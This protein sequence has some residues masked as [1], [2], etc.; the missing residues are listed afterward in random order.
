MIVYKITNIINGKVY[1]GQ[2]KFT[3]EERFEHHCK[4]ALEE[5]A[6]FE[7]SRAIKKYGKEKFKVEVLEE[8]KTRE[9][10]CFFEIA[11]IKKYNSTNRDVGY[12]MTNGGEGG[13]TYLSKSDEEMKQIKLKISEA[14]KG[15]NNGNSRNIK[16][17][18]VLTGNVFHFGSVYECSRFLREKWNLKKDDYSSRLPLRKIKE[19]EM[20]GFTNLVFDRYLFADEE[21]DFATHFAKGPFIKGSCRW[22][23]Y[24]LNGNLVYVSNSSRELAEHFGWKYGKDFTS[25]LKRGKYIL[26]RLGIERKRKNE[27]K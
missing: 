8:V 20:Y 7:L 25:K 21:K 19:T 15:A 4:K 11:Y 24:D 26:E 5:N 3:A 13:N 27:N 23:V 22:K 14:N 9:E 10:A 6:D 17:K 16:M 12:N 18:D 2:T 1:I